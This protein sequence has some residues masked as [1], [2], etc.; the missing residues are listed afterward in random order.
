MLLRDIKFFFLVLVFFSFSCGSYKH[1][2]YY[3]NL[4]NKSTKESINNYTN[5]IIQPGDVLAIH[6][7]SANHQAD[8]EFNSNGNYTPDRQALTDVN[9]SQ[10]VVQGYQVDSE[11]YIN[12]PLAGS[13]KVSDLPM[14]EIVSKLETIL[15][16]Y[17]TKPIV[18]V[19]ILNFKISVLGDV[20]SP[21]VY[22]IAN[23]KVNINE[24]LSLAGDLNI[25][26]IRT[27]VLLIRETNGI[28]EFYHIDLTS[29]NLFN[30][31]YYYLN[32]NDIIYVRP[33][34]K[35]VSPEGVG[36]QKAALGVSVLSLLG[37]LLFRR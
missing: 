28:R 20:K 26:G 29:A 8:V 36:F 31:P 6:V 1:I 16:D 30:S 4:G 5:L 35:K 27:D 2:P 33:N 11:G 14:R 24:A 3:Q 10:N 21:G 22:N 23:G 32:N 37:Y 18:N 34:R 25:T 12:L 13:V 17:F 19:R 7:S 9:S 15:Q